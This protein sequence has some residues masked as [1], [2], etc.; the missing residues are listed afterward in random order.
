MSKFTLSKITLFVL[1]TLQIFS[2]SAVAKNACLGKQ[3][4]IVAIGDSIT[5][6]GNYPDEYSYRLPLSIMLK[7]AGYDIDFIGTQHTGLNESFKWPAGFDNDHE[8]FYGATTAELASYLQTDLAKIPP[9][10]LA[11]IHLGTSDFESYNIFKSVV[12]PMHSIILQLRK[13]NPNVRILISQI[14][15]NGLKA[16]YLRAHLNLLASYENLLKSPVHTV[17]DYVEFTK[18]DTIDG[19]H[20]S[21]SG[22]EKMAKAWSKQI[23][24]LCDA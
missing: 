17:P 3:L 9:P 18:N 23:K 7:E 8:G 10:D 24:L 21:L 19:M 11:L 15:L 22:Q 14:H 1:L 16:K 6:G 13:R 2:T 12:V 5:Q 4:K 20:P